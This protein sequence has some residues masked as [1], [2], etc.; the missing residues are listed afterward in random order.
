MHGAKDVLLAGLAHGILL[1]VGK[2]HHVLTLVAKV[3]GKIGSHVADVVDAS[4]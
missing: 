1:V 4:S 3:L 2:N